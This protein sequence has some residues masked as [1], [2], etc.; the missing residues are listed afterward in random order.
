LNYLREGQGRS[1][2]VSVNTQETLAANRILAF[3]NGNNKTT[4]TKT[5]NPFCQLPSCP[6]TG[7]ILPTTGINLEFANSF[8][9]SMPSQ[10]VNQ[11]TPVIFQVTGR[12]VFSVQAIST[13]SQSS[14]SANGLENFV[15]CLP[16][17]S[18]PVQLSFTNVGTTPVNSLVASVSTVPPAAT[19]LDTYG[20]C[21]GVCGG[22]LVGPGASIVGPNGA[23]LGVAGASVYAPFVL[24]PPVSPSVSSSGKGICVSSR[25]AGCNT[26]GFSINGYS[27][28]GYNNNV[29]APPVASGTITSLVSPLAITGANTFYI[30]TINPGE[31]QNTAS[32]QG[33]IPGLAIRSNVSC[34]NIHN[35]PNS[36]LYVQSTYT[37]AIGQRFTEVN[38]LNMPISQAK[39]YTPG[40]GA[41]GT[42]HAPLRHH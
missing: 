30:G 40:F 27:I 15:S 20:G 34:N 4:F 9:K 1:A 37:N 17:A 13:Q 38:Q 10:I 39:P 31:S 26:N 5:F 6:A 14:K 8:N 29:A 32:T 22:G 19:T 25:A 12:T 23:P 41:P 3:V 35:V 42:P 24:P 28:A 11:V 36:S 21:G 18:T 2:S 16:G 7:A 33:P